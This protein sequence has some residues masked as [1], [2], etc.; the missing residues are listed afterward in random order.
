MDDRAS[1]EETR[2]AMNMIGMSASEQSEVFRTVAAI[3]HV[4]N[5]QFSGDSKA[6]VSNSDVAAIAAR[7]LQVPQTTLVE[8]RVPA[9]R[10]PRVAKAA[11]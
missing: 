4:G 5:I 3:L 1:F 10:A 9:Q 2:T 11:R 8:V 6:A 7:L